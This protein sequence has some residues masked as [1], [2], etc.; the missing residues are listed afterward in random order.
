MS[1]RALRRL[2]WRRCQVWPNARRGLWMRFARRSR[3]A[4][5]L[6]LARVGRLRRVARLVMVP[7]EARSKEFF[8]DF[9]DHQHECVGVMSGGRSG[10]L[11][12]DYARSDLRYCEEARPGKQGG[13]C[14]GQGFGHF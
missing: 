13:H 11:E 10:F 8:Y 5:A 2:I 1:S 6:R 4:A 12:V 9:D 14:E 3:G 7:L